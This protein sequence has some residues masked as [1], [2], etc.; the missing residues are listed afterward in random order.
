MKTSKGAGYICASDA[1]N[2]TTCVEPYLHMSI[3]DHINVPIATNNKIRVSYS[4]TPYRAL[5]YMPAPYMLLT[6]RGTADI[7]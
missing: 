6:L 4:L 1:V 5:Y 7:H 2:I 3:A